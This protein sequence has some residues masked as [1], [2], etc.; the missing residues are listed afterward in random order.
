MTQKQQLSAPHNFTSLRKK[1][2]TRESSDV[3]S[4]SVNTVHKK[5]SIRKNRVAAV[6]LE[7]DANCVGGSMNKRR[8]SLRCHAIGR[9][10]LMEQ[11]AARRENSNHQGSPDHVRMERLMASSSF[12]S[13]SEKWL[14]MMPELLPRLQTVAKAS[15]ALSESIKEMVDLYEHLAGADKDRAHVIFDLANRNS[16]AHCESLSP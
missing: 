8:C 9:D 7:G 3:E 11:V 5:G 6:P 13:S 10:A 1:T 2:L 15:D 14:S 16:S 4:K 12:Q